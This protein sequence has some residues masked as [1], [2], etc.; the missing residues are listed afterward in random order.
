MTKICITKNKQMNFFF[1][2]TEMKAFIHRIIKICIQRCPIQE[3]QSTIIKQNTV[4]SSMFPEHQLSWI[5]LLRQS[6]K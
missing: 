6:V 2:C 5:S 1:I 4:L 3:Y